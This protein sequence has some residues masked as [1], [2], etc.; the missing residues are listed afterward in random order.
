M[1]RAIMA[2]NLWPVLW[3]RA[4]FPDPITIFVY[5]ACSL[6]SEPIKASNLWPVPWNR[7]MF[8]DPT[9]IF[10]YLACSLWSE[11]IKASNLWPVPWRRQ[12]SLILQQYDGPPMVPSY[13]IDPCL[14]PGQGMF[15]A[16]CSKGSP[17]FLH[18][19]IRRSQGSLIL[20]H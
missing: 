14:S 20:S 10:A 8:P 1:V 3:R 17:L 5:M 16:P 7:A 11:P 4:M 12:G 19:T 15:R 18:N 6:W 2:S 9:T 13:V